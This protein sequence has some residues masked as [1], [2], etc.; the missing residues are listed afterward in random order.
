MTHTKKPSPLVGEGGGG[1]A[2]RGKLEQ[3]RKNGFC[4]TVLNTCL[5]FLNEVKNL[6][7]DIRIKYFSLCTH[8]CL[9][10]SQ[11]SALLFVFRGIG[12]K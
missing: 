9:Y 1:A 12:E 6:A 11:G 10:R 8:A 7:K 5:S 2:G 4:R 3:K